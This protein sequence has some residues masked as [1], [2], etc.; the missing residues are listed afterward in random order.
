[1]KLGKTEQGSRTQFFASCFGDWVRL[2]ILLQ[3]NWKLTE[4]PEICYFGNVETLIPYTL[5]GVICSGRTSFC[6]I[7]FIAASNIL[8]YINSCFKYPCNDN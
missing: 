3:N 6:A 5:C 2:Q 4:N 7:K 8:S 1:M